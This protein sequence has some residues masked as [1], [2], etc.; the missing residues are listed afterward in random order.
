MTSIWQFHFL[1]SG[2]SPMKSIAKRSNGAPTGIYLRA[3]LG[4][5]TGD[6]TAA[7]VVTGF[8]IYVHILTNFK[9][10]VILENQVSGMPW[11]QMAT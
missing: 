10:I 7:Q 5:L 11:S 9:P 1:D 2:S 6:L 3:A 4:F 8:D